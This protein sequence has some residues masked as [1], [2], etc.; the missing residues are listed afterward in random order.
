MVDLVV[1]GFGVNGVRGVGVHGTGA[2]DGS[3]LHGRTRRR[4]AQ[5]DVEAEILCRVVVVRVHVDV[6][7]CSRSLRVHGCI[8][9]GGVRCRGR[10]WRIRP[11]SPGSR[12][13]ELGASTVVELVVA[14]HRG[15][16]RGTCRRGPIHDG[17]GNTSGN[18]GNGFTAGTASG[19]RRGRR[20][21]GRTRHR[22]SR[23][24]TIGQQ[25]SSA[26]KRAGAGEHGVSSRHKQ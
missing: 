17:I 14:R 20:R 19:N 1:P 10:P 5:T 11:R 23:S 8:A 25:R 3:G 7:G 22:N 6:H 21:T 16:T 13:G 15:R 4:P 9:L 12:Y 18:I 2:L 26:G 24:N